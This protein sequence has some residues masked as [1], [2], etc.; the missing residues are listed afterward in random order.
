MVRQA[1]VDLNGKV[2][3][4]SGGARGLG[5][6]VAG[7]LLARG[8]KVALAAR[9]LDEARVAAAGLAGPVLPLGCDVADPGQVD[10]LAASAARELGPIDVWVNAV[11]PAGPFGPLR[12]LS[13]ADQRPALEAGVL[14]TWLGTMAALRHMAA[15][16]ACSIVNVLG[17]TEP[18]PRPDNALWDANKAWVRSFTLA[19]AEEQR[20][21]G[22][23]VIGFEPGLLETRSALMPEV[24]PGLEPVFKARLSRLRLQALPPEVPAKRLVEAIEAGARGLVR[25]TPALWSVRGPLR[26]LFGGRPDFVITPR[27]LPRR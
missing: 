16:T 27:A 23:A 22:V 5:F 15:R 1:R 26:M 24:T 8:A 20:G 6:A 18:L 7:A 2:A 10:A 12:E 25:G 13:P 14:G 17:R 4:V 11:G 21:T 3:V 9:T 19:L